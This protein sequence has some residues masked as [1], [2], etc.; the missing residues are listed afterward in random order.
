MSKTADKIV[1]G[2]MRALARAAT[3]IED[4]RPEAE[5]LLRELFPLRRPWVGARGGLGFTKDYFM[6]N[7]IAMLRSIRIYRGR[8]NMQKFANGHHP[9]IAFLSCS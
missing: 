7:W 6:E 1:S 5:P 2:N 4:R 8:V 9:V 3:W